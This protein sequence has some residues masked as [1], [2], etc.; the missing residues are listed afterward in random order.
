M[1]EYSVGDRVRGEDEVGGRVTYADPEC[2]GCVIWDDGDESDYSWAQLCRLQ[3]DV[4]SYE[5]GRPAPTL[6]ALKTIA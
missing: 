3:P 4:D 5:L 1:Y 6:R 2:G